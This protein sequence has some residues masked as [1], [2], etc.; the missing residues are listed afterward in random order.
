VR[1]SEGKITLIGDTLPNRLMSKGDDFLARLPNLYD[2]E[3][4]PFPVYA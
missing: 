3:G 2:G 4:R 1:A